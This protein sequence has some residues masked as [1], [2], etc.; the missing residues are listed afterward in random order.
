MGNLQCYYLVR[1]YDLIW[2]MSPVL[3]MIVDVVCAT[4]L[5]VIASV[6]TLIIRTSAQTSYITISHMVANS[7]F[8]KQSLR[9]SS[10]AIKGSVS[11]LMTYCE[12][13]HSAS[14]DMDGGMLDRK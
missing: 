3:G 14:E 11:A 2:N 9:S 4:L 8:N 1:M 7:Q 10:I 6:P 5:W 13:E 12:R